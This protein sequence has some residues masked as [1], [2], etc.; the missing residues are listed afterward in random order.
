VISQ[1]S[2]GGGITGGVFSND[3]VELH[4]SGNWPIDLSSYVLQFA[5]V[6]AGAIWTAAPLP[7]MTLPPGGYFLIA[8]ASGGS[9]LTDLPPA[10]FTPDP[11]MP[12]NGNNGKLVLTRS[13]TPLAVGCPALTDTVDVVGYGTGSCF[14]AMAV[15]RLT[16]ATSALRNDSGCADTDN[17]GADF[18]VVT[19]TA[20]TPPRNGMSPPHVCACAN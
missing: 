9:T 11:E 15:P 19:L 2:G 7:A 12:L 14:E 5:A 13:A 20:T 18:S 1:L 4:N 16:N 10:D 3:F 8:G 6:P 17:N